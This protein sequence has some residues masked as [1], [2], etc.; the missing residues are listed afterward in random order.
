MTP[1]HKYCV[2]ESYIF[3]IKISVYAMINPGSLEIWTILSSVCRAL[4]VSLTCILSSSPVPWAVSFS[5]TVSSD[6]L[7][8]LHFLES[9][10]REH[11]ISVSDCPYFQISLIIIPLSKSTKLPSPM[12]TVFHLEMWKLFP[13]YILMLLAAYPDHSQCSWC[14]KHLQFWMQK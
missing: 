13:N 5:G 4:R 10:H 8:R 14:F 2:P 12:Y 9:L 3:T 11:C 1:V 7:F 6:L